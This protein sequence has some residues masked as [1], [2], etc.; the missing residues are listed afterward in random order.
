MVIL[1]QKCY[2]N[3]GQILSRQKLLLKTEEMKKIYDEVATRKIPDSSGNRTPS[4][5]ASRYTD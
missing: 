4:S 3:I 2:F 5:Q 1:S